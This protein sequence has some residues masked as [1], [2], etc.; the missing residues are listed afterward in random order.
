MSLVALRFA[1]IPFAL[2]EMAAVLAWYHDGVSTFWLVIVSMIVMFA[3]FSGVVWLATHGKGLRV[4]LD[5]S[6]LVA[7][8]S[9]VAFGSQ[10]IAFGAMI[11]SFVGGSADTDSSFGSRLRTDAREIWV[12]AI[13]SVIVMVAFALRNRPAVWLTPEGVEVRRLFRSKRAGWDEIEFDGAVLAGARRRNMRIVVRLRADPAGDELTPSIDFPA[14]NLYVSAEDLATA[15]NWYAAHPDR[16]ATIGT[17]TA[18]HAAWQLSA[19]VAAASPGR[20]R[21]DIALPLDQQLR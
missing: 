12:A 4:A 21:D 6:A 10:I 2:A 18:E 13:G 16:R 5:R 20:I 15:I 7:V 1:A 9:P 14:R 19:P 17:D 11:A 3:L 8:A